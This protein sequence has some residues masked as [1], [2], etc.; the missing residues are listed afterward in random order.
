MS[1]CPGLIKPFTETSF[2]TQPPQT[3]SGMMCDRWKVRSSAT[4]LERHQATA[5]VQ[6][7]G[8][9]SL[10]RFTLWDDKSFYL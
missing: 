2:N 4:S 1:R 5:I 3:F 6:Q 9:S 10:A 7:Y 8:H